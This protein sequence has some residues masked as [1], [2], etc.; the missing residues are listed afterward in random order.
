MEFRHQGILDDRLGRLL[1]GFH[2]FNRR[3]LQRVGHQEGTVDGLVAEDA[4]PV[5]GV[6]SQMDQA[7]QNLE[8]AEPLK[9]IRNA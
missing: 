2:D 7:F 4:D 6:G 1:Q 5:V 9:R 3:F 8:S